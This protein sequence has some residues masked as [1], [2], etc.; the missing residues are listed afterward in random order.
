MLAKFTTSFFT[1]PTAKIHDIQQLLSFLRARE[2]CF[3]LKKTVM[4]NILS[5]QKNRFWFE[6]IGFFP[7][8]ATLESETSV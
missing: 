5:I 6:K 2:R 8:L 1:E 4:V 3:F 7:Y